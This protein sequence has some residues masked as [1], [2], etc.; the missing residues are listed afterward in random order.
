MA[1]WYTH[2]AMNEQT[3]NT[4]HADEGLPT[5]AGA[6]PR[7]RYASPSEQAEADRRRQ[8]VVMLG[9]P[10]TQALRLASAEPAAFLG[11]GDTLGRIAPGWRADL[12]AFDPGT[13]AVHQAWVAGEPRLADQE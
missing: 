8:R 10:L 2:D 7:R 12:V 1:A 11:L 5:I 9:V 3:S 6:P 13:I 4:G